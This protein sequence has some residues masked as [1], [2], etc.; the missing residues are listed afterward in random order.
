MKRIT[1]TMT[2]SKGNVILLP[3]PFTDL[4]TTKVRPAVVVSSDQ[5]DRY[6]D[7]FVTP[8]TSRLTNLLAGEFVLEAWQAVGLNVPS[9]IKRGCFLIEKSLI[10][11]KIGVLSNQDLRKIDRFLKKWLELS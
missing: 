1:Y 9:A 4:S 6:V 7:V 5:Q 2:Y 8:I 3:Y 11:Q 10:L